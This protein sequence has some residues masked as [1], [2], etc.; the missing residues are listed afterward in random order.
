MSR[1][2]L[3]SLVNDVCLIL[4]LTKLYVELSSLQQELVEALRT[5]DNLRKEA[6][7]LHTNIILS[8]CHLKA[9]VG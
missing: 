8:I 4:D 5:I 6:E 2:D 3:Y 9:N 1:T 7:V